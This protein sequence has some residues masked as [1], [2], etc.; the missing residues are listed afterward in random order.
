MRS[1]NLVLKT[2]Y[3]NLFSKH[4]RRKDELSIMKELVESMKYITLGEQDRIWRHQLDNLIQYKNLS[5]A[6]LCYFEG[7][8][9]KEN[10]YA[11]SFDKARDYTS[12]FHGKRV[13][14]DIINSKEPVI[15]NDL[16]LHEELNMIKGSM[17]TLP[18]FS[19]D[20]ILGA[21]I[22]LKPTPYGFSQRD[23]KFYSVVR[24]HLM[25]TLSFQR[26]YFEKMIEERKKVSCLWPLQRRW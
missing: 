16:S 18:M 5:G 25:N 22:L 24:D 23:I 17:C 2:N 11:A 4:E 10:I 26:I 13:L 12:L 7:R 9:K 20:D 15:I 21:L 19:G 8:Q 6:V 1:N 3:L 14:E